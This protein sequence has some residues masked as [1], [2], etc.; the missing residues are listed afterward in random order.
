[1]LM[2][3]L[4]RLSRKEKYVWDVSKIVHTLDLSDAVHLPQMYGHVRT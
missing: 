4:S 1:M 3:T 2:E